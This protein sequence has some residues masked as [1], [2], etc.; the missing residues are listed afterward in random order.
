VTYQINVTNPKHVSK[1]VEK[2][3]VNGKQVEGN[4]IRVEVGSGEVNVEV[5][6][7]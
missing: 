3:T 2:V 5:V 4:V 7:G 6:M 1:G